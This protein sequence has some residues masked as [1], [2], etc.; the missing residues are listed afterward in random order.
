MVG[1]P[2]RAGVLQKERNARF[3]RAGNRF[4]GEKA[5]VAPNPFRAVAQE[6]RANSINRAV[7]VAQNRGLNLKDAMNMMLKGEEKF[8][9]ALDWTKEKLQEH[10]RE[11]SKD[12]MEY[13]QY[14]KMNK[15]HM[16]VAE[17]EQ[18]MQRIEMIKLEREELV[19]QSKMRSKLVEILMRN[20]MSRGRAEEV[21]KEMV[22]SIRGLKQQE[23]LTE[24]N[25]K[26]LLENERLLV[27][28]AEAASKQLNSE[29]I[30]RALKSGNV[31]RT[32]LVAQLL[33]QALEA[34]KLI[35]PQQ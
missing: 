29:G 35:Q 17:Q 9:G 13:M 22:V 20:G 3:S 31:N 24:E 26:S 2:R 21:A 15:Q 4:V 14:L 8:R 6:A 10:T 28:I 19:R 34:N 32:E 23:A 18:L 7:Q 27:Q 30:I 33:Q 12:E 1:F 16:E 11:L 5:K 25:Y